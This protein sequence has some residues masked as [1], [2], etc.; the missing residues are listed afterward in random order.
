MLISDSIGRIAAGDVDVLARNGRIRGRNPLIYMHSAASDAREIMGF[1]L[2]STLKIARALIDDLQFDLAA[3]TSLLSLGTAGL[4]ASWPSSF[5]GK[6]DM[7][8]AIAYHRANLGGSSGP[9]V[10]VGT[11]MGSTNCLV[12]AFQHPGEVAAI[13][14]FSPVWDLYGYYA[15]N[16]QGTRTDIATAWG[17]TYPTLPHAAAD[18]HQLTLTSGILVPPLY[19]VDA[20]NDPYSTSY[21]SGKYTTWRNAWTGGVT[22]QA[23][24][25]VGH[26]EG[27]TAAADM[28]PIKAWLQAI[29]D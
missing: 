25:A 29:L 17:V 5:A 24:G 22:R 18:I 2:P 10:L 19:L 4:P 8:T 21:N 23:L 27:T 3:P 11:S 9:I 7:E 6:G 1:S 12:Y 20:S 13:I 14:L 28:T 16:T 26:G 15:A